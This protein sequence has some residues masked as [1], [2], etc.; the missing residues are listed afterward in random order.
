[1]QIGYS[2]ASTVIDTIDLGS[3]DSGRLI[4]PCVRMQAEVSFISNII[5]I[6]FIFIFSSN[7]F[8]LF[9]GQRVVES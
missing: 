5:H 4:Y 6:I 1:M 9:V 3:Y 2:C 8:V 7:D